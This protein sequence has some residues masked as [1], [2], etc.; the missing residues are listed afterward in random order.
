MTA[1]YTPFF[2]SA[3]LKQPFGTAKVS[4]RRIIS[5]TAETGLEDEQIIS[6]SA[7]KALP[8]GIYYARSQTESPGESDEKM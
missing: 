1:I 8:G 7:W 5:G 3:P 2:L 4:M 6:I